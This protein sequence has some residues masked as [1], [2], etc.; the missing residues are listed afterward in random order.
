M[1]TFW[2][3]RS[4]HAAARFQPFLNVNPKTQ[5]ES[6]GKGTREKAKSSVKVDSQGPQDWE[7]IKHKFTN[8]Q[9]KFIEE[10]IRDAK[11]SRWPFK[12][13]SPMFT[14]YVWPNGKV[15]IIDPDNLPAFTRNE[16]AR[17]LNANL[18]RILSGTATC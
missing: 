9:V 7:E 10:T 8:R 3:L 12:V 6:S 5:S 17:L 4:K 18:S 16:N 2:N 11:T 15:Q 14:L 13:L 1:D